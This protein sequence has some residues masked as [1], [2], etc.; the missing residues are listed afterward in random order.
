MALK[1]EDPCGGFQHGEVVA[2]INEKM[3]RHAKGPE[4]Y[5]EN[6]SLSWEEVEDKLRAILEDGA[7]P[8]EAKEAC[9]WSS[10]A[11][12]VRFACRQGQLHER[13][14]QRL[15]DL[16]KVHKST[17]E[18]LASDLKKL[19][20]QQEMER[21]EAAFRLRQTQANLME[22][23]KERDLL[24]WKL[25]RA[26]RLPELSPCPVS[27]LCPASPEL[28]STVPTSLQEL[29]SPREQVDKE[30]VRAT[31]S[32]AGTE[33]AG[34]KK[35][36]VSVA[37]ATTATA[38][39]AAGGGGRQKDAEGEEAAKELG[40]GL[41]QLLGAL[42]QKNYPSGGQREGGLRS[43]ETAMFYFSE[44]MEPGST[45][46]PAPLPVQLPASFTYSYSCP[47]LPFPDAPTASPPAAM[48]RAGAPSQSSPH[49]GPSN[50]SLW[51]DVGAQGI[52]PE[53]QR[54]K[55]GFDPHGQGRP[56]VF[57][58]PGDWD[59]PWCKAVNF[60]RREICFRCGR[61]IWLQNP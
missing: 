41:V 19:T 2:F 9:A 23:R 48:F 49:W 29:G 39:G 34:E 27:P 5:L 25:L 14:V 43:A 31:A 24:K 22:M 44:T 16:A 32:G 57:R 20:A 13:R 30:P 36:E 7:V 52:D 33:R 8:S 1:P 58:R 17:T 45:V 4:F 47:L 21:K 50:V 11:L 46:S 18:E 40:G 28:V 54:D 12:G 26:V 56:P 15:Q 3:A 55:R 61:G 6:I 10:L 59:C 53:S 38:A 51:P 37:A 60:S 35:E 42:E